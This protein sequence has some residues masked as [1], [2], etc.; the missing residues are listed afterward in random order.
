MSDTLVSCTDH[1]HDRDVMLNRR[2]VLSRRALLGQMALLVGA[3]AVG[4]G[5]CDRT[6]YS[7][8]IAELMELSPDRE[9]AAAIGRAYLD[10][11]RTRRN[12]L[13]SRLATELDWTPELDRATLTSR[14]LARIESDFRD[15]RT[16]R[17]E[18]WILSQTEVWWAA[19]VALA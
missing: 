11:K 7:L 13:A 18:D 12:R 6:D 1:E 14:L 8:L 15:N 17:V 3:G 9:A 19:L 2:P 10:T 5:G 4:L 16:L